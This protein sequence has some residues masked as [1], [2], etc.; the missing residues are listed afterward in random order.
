MIGHHPQTQL[1]GPHSDGSPDHQATLSRINCSSGLSAYFT[2][3]GCRLGV[4]RAMGGGGLGLWPRLG[5]HEVPAHHRCQDAQPGGLCPAP[6]L[7]APT[8][9]GAADVTRCIRKPKPYSCSAC[10]TSGSGPMQAMMTLFHWPADDRS[11]A[12]ST[13]Y[14]CAP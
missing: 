3:P 5:Q 14:K 13:P 4:G 12:Y 6:P 1:R 10:C 2:C 8:A 11:H 7:G 9:Q